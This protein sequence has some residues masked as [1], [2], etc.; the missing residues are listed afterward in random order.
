MFPLRDT[1]PWRRFPALTL[2]LI[3]INGLVFLYELSL[4]PNVLDQAIAI[5]GVVPSRVAH[6]VRLGGDPGD[7]WRYVPLVSSMFLHGGWAHLIGNM[8]FLWVFGAKVEDVLGRGRYLSFYL[9]AGV[10]AALAQA[11]R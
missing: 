1:V 11:W 3:A 5:F 8:W 9:V 10:I 4:P 6:W 7:P 2:L